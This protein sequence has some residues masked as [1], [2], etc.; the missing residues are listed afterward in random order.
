MP[1]PAR[2]NAASPI[3]NPELKNRNQRSDIRDPTSEIEGSPAA[4]FIAPYGFPAANAARRSRTTYVK[5]GAKIP[6]FL[7]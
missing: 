6:Y 4:G 7:S 2:Y 5:T 1:R 3:K